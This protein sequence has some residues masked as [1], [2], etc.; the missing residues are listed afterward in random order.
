MTS[1]TLGTQ[2]MQA[3]RPGDA[4]LGGLQWFAVVLLLL[5]A[6]FNGLDGI[7]AI[8]HSH[9]FVANAH[10]VVGDLRAWGWVFLIL[11]IAQLLVAIAIANA[12]SWARWAGVAIL[13]LNALAQMFA[14]SSYPLWS[15]IIIAVDIV[16]IYGLCVFDDRRPQTV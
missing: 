1:S 7:A 6:F 11:G 2:G 3:D 8:A 15:L 9:V 14:L 12:I 16:A 13:G 5:L 10:F 4:R